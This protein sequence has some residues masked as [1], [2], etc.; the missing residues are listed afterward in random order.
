MGELRLAVK[1]LIGS[2]EK[3]SQDSDD[4][5][6][7]VFVFDEA[8]SLFYSDSSRSDSWRY[9]ALNWLFSCLREFPVWF[10][11]FPWNLK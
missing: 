7:L 6:R 3:H 1:S 11:S 2:L 4:N 8:S 5:H 10:F 9:V